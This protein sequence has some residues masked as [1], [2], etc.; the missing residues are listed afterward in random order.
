MPFGFTETYSRV[1]HPC[2][3]VVTGDLFLLV[4]SLDSRESFDE[5]KRLQEQIIQVKGERPGGG[6]GT[7]G[8]AGATA[9]VLR[10]RKKVTVPIVVVGNKSDLDVERQVDSSDLRGVVDAVPGNACVESSAKKNQNIEEI[11]L[12]LFLLANLPTEMSPSLHRKVTPMYVGSP[13]PGSIR[14]TVTLRRRLSD[15]CGAIAPNAR[16]PSIRTDLLLMQMQTNKKKLVRADSEGQK[17]SR[18]TIQ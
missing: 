6:G 3:Y 9:G 10:G 7:D 13:S 1:A 12:K 15:A 2:C 5:V 17:D 4:F 8:A 18:C 16:R 11:F 14:R